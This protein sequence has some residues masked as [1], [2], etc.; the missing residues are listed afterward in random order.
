MLDLTWKFF[1]MTG[2][3]DAYLLMKEM[4][5][6]DHAQQSAGS[7]TETLAKEQLN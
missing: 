1:C 6:E 7:E 3:I 5:K 2:N 4:E